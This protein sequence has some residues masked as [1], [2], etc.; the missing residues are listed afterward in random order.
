MKYFLQAVILTLTIL[1]GIGQVLPGQPAPYL[2]QDPPGT[3][4]ELFLPEMLGR[5]SVNE[6]GATLSWDGRIVIYRHFEPGKADPLPVWVLEE[7]DGQW[8]KPVRPE[9]DSEYREWDFN[10]DRTGDGFYFTSDRKAVIGGQEAENSNI[11]M[12]RK[13]ACGWTEPELLAAPVNT[14]KGFSGYPS[15]TREGNIYFHSSREGGLGQTD[16]YMA[17]PKGNSEFDVK[18]LGEPVNTSWNDLD[19]SIAPDGTYLIFMSTRPVGVSERGNM[20][21]SFRD[22]EGLWLDPVSINGIVGEAGHPCISA[23]GRFFFFTRKVEGQTDIYWVSTEAIL[24]L[25]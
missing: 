5:K 10:F 15:I 19:P 20:Y 6:G 1:Q 3:T 4:P 12:V 11:W 25:K 9:F 21:V 8:S 22:Q 23:D 24:R 2:G 14:V 13:R 18:N 7:K 16:L 17:V